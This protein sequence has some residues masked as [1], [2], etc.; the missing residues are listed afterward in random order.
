MTIEYS[1]VDI[2]CN[3]KCSYC[4]QEPMR[5]A[6]NISSRADWDR[7]KAELSRQNYQF[8][9]HGGEP[10]LAPIEHIEEVFKFGLER[11]GRNGI[12]TNGTLITKRHIDLF[13]KYR[14]GVGISIDGPGVCNSLRRAGTH[15]ETNAQTTRTLDSIERLCRAGIIPSLIVTVH[16][17]NGSAKGLD[18]LCAWFTEL[19]SLGIKN[20]NL[21]MLE[22][23]KGMEHLALSEEEN[24]QAFRRLYQFSLLSKIQFQPFT[25]IRR[26][27]SG[28]DAHKV[29]CIWNA[30]DSLTTNAVQG[31]SR[32]GVRSNC[33]RTNKDGINWVKADV[34]G[35][36]RYIILQQIP[37]EHGGCKDCR[38]FV[39]CKGNCPGTAIDGD[40]RNRTVHCSTWYDL[41]AA[42]E[43]ELI[44]ECRLPISKNPQQLKEIL[45]KL[46]AEWSK[47]EVTKQDQH[48]DS[49]HHDW[50]CTSVA[51]SEPKGISVTWL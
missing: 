27:L 30:C 32:Q 20:I 28:D 46:N 11:F 26:L 31:V 18:T 10:L 19:E 35:R 9:L 49:P 15:E 33:G 37:Q 7:A 12:Q 42:E 21:H 24:R 40:W 45:D 1:P 23:E 14:V 50:H 17:M 44:R 47:I 16:K 22:V 43:I 34:A 6:G 13:K 39:F 25:D 48:Q 38:F 29:N 2:A 41:F 3:L 51:S 36:E 5:D 4:Y 8:S